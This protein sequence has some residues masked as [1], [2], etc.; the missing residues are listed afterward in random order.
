MYWSASATLR[1]KSS[2]RTTLM[3]APKSG[4]GIEM[5]GRAM[6]VSAGKGRR[7]L[8]AFMAAVIEAGGGARNPNSTSAP[9]HWLHCANACAIARG[10]TV[11]VDLTDRMVK[12]RAASTVAS[13]PLRRSS[14]SNIESVS[15]EKRLFPPPAAFAAQANVTRADLDRLNAE[16]AS[17]YEGFWAR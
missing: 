10:A 6:K 8:D 2:W 11:W 15:H 16:A 4:Y 7:A 14:M 12:A 13:I 1:I 5:S 17:D 9:S 3:A